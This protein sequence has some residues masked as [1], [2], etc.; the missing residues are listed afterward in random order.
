MLIHGDK[1]DL[2]PISHSQSIYE[3]FQKEHVKTQFITIPGGGHGFRG[4]DAKRANAALVAWFEETLLKNPTK[5][6]K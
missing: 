6:G 5:G 2:V 1:D 3:A 4:D